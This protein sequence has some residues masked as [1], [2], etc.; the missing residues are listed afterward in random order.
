MKKIFFF[1][2][3]LFLGTMMMF[4]QETNIKGA[5]VSRYDATQITNN[6]N[7][8]IVPLVA[9]L[10]VSKE[11]QEHKIV[12]TVVL[13]NLLKKEKEIEYLARIENIIKIKIEELKARA[14][15]ELVEKTNSSVI[16]T[17]LYSTK[18]IS[19]DGLE[20]TLEVKIKGFPAVYNNFRNIKASDTTIVYLNN[21]IKQKEV[22][23]I[24]IDNKTNDRTEKTIEVKR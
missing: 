7:L 11:L 22:D 1:F 10:N 21:I 4:A 9:E 3:C 5:N 17:P 24:S 12:E 23:V 18:T 13:P 16:V 8:F 20:I 19:S 2:V 14:L 6:G 15:Y